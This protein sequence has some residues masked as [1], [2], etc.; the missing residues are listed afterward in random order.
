MEEGTEQDKGRRQ[1]EKERRGGEER[2][3]HHISPAGYCASLGSSH[4]L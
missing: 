2:A 3:E 1:A 4:P